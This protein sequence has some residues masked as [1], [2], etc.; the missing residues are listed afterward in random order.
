MKYKCSEC[1][2]PTTMKVIL[3]KYEESGLDNV[4]LENIPVYQCACGASVASIFQVGKLNNL[5]AEQ[6][7]QKPNLLTGAEIRFLRKNMYWPSNV[8]AKQ[9]GVGKTTL[10]KW[11]NKIQ[12]HG[13][14]YDRL[15]RLVY[16]EIKGTRKRVAARVLEML[17]EIKLSE[18]ESAAII[19][20]ERTDKDYKVYYRPI[21]VPSTDKSKKIRVFMTEPQWVS[22]DS[23][24]TI[25]G[26]SQTEDFFIFASNKPL[27]TKTDKH[28][29]ERRV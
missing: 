22:T 5:I 28:L 25:D 15:I 24:C 2:K 4:F 11:E 27:S 8:F 17:S 26:H 20:A 29:I 19:I 10:S 6:L 9:L 18:A 1:G 13:D 7:I 23:S 3:Y 21:L 14:R 16:I 12:R